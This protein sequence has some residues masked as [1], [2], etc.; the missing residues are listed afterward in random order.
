MS[1]EQFINLKKTDVA[2]G[3]KDFP[4]GDDPT[5]TKPPIFTQEN[6]HLEQTLFA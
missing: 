5:K 4:N 3:F 2:V 1:P 6:T